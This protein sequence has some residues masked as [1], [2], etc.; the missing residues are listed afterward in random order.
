MVQ[1]HAVSCGPNWRKRVSSALLL[2][3][4]RFCIYITDDRRCSCG[5]GCSSVYPCI[6]IHV[7]VVGANYTGLRHTSAVLH[8]NEIIMT[9][10]V[11]DIFHFSSPKAAQSENTRCLCLNTFILSHT[12]RWGRVAYLSHHAVV[13]VIVNP[14][15]VTPRQDCLLLQ[16]TT[17]AITKLCKRLRLRPW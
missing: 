9:R 6:Q 5:K 3:S 13:V 7:M 2:V 14:P 12:H 16:F 1:D 11:K 17:N 8:E 15:P 10:K 4:L